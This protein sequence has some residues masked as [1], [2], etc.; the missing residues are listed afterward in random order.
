MVFYVIFF[1]L[2]ATINSSSQTYAGIYDKRKDWSYRKFFFS[3]SSIGEEFFLELKGLQFKLKS[4][5]LGVLTAILKTLE[6]FLAI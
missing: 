4:M 2:H 3:P 5:K 1:L 6:C